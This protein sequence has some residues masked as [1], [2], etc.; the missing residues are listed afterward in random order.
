MVKKVFFA[1]A[2]LVA[3][4]GLAQEK[5]NYIQKGL[6]KSNF[7]F[8]QGFMLRHKSNNVY[9]NGNLEYFSEKNISFRGDCSWYLDTRQKEAILKKNILVLFGAFL[10][11]PNGKSDFSAGVQPGF[12]FTQ[13]VLNN[14][15]QQNYPIRMMPAF[16]VSFEYNLYFSKYFNFFLSTNYLVSRYRGSETG[17]INL[18]EFFISGGLGIHIKAFKEK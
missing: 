8:N 10:H 18:D 4:Q 15:S 14:L 3:F 9:V 16:S 1:I 7:G 5:E 12:T 11:I 13:P 17:S 2:L 6:L